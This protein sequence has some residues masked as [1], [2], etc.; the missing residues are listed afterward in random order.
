MGKVDINQMYDELLHELFGDIIGAVDVSTLMVR[1]SK[2][3]EAMHKIQEKYGVKQG[4][5]DFLP[6]ILTCVGRSPKIVED[7]GT[8]GE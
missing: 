1:R 4:H 2:Y 8:E 7:E 6:W 3:T 5:K